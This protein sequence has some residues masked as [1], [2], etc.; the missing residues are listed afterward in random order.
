MKKETIPALQIMCKQCKKTVD[1]TGKIHLYDRYTERNS[2]LCRDCY[3][4]KQKEEAEE[5]ADYHKLPSLTGSEKAISW[6]NVIRQKWFASRTDFENSFLLRQTSASTIIQINKARSVRGLLK[7]LVNSPELQPLQ[8]SPKQIDYAKKLFKAVVLE[9]LLREDHQ[10]PLLYQAL[11]QEASEKRK[12]G[13]V[14]DLLKE[15]IKR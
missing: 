5:F 13:E 14:I 8:G 11:I 9:D 12:A 7:G 3:F 1:Y 6:A 4:K 2:W 15:A 10:Q